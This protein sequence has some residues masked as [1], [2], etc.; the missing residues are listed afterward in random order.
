M[1]L[2]VKNDKF[3]HQPNGFW[4]MS[5]GLAEEVTQLAVVRDDRCIGVFEVEDMLYSEDRGRA[6][7]DIAFEAS[8]SEEIKKLV[9][10]WRIFGGKF[11]GKGYKLFT[12]VQLVKETHKLMNKSLV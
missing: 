9:S 5:K 6:V 1:L 7:F 12:G 4:H 8:S 2:V 3:A 11:T 10:K